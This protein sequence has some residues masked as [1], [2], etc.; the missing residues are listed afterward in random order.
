MRE[1]VAMSG[2]GLEQSK[3]KSSGKARASPP[4][5]D[6]VR[7]GEIGA[8]EARKARRTLLD[9]VEQGEEV[10]ISRRGRRVARLVQDDGIDRDQRA[11]MAA[12]RIIE[13]R[14]G[15]TLGGLKIKDLINDGRP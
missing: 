9:L 7:T 4:A 11:L 8:R 1:P 6:G 10:V 12:E 3:N 15:V 2:D 5:K 14:K 13:R